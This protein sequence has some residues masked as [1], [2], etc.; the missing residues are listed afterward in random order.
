M[1]KEV[2][3]RT[4]LLLIFD[5]RRNTTSV[6][7]NI[8]EVYK[9]YVQEFSEYGEPDMFYTE[10]LNSPK[11]YSETFSKIL[12]VLELVGTEPAGAQYKIILRV[13]GGGVMSD[14]Q[15]TFFI[16]TACRYNIELLFT[17]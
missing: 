6:L 11:I 12:K 9:K 1:A 15:R 3:V 5:S 10:E 13:V 14:S 8:D 17:D 4:S 7:E 16:S 2:T